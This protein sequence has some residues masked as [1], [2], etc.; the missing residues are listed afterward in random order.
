MITKLI[1]IA[2]IILIIFLIGKFFV[3]N[4]FYRCKLLNDILK[5]NTPKGFV[6]SQGRIYLFISII[7]YFTTLAL[8]FGKS[9]K[10]NL[11]VDMNAI[12]QVIEAEQWAILLMAGYVF[13]N[14][15]LEVIKIMMSSSKNKTANDSTTTTTTTSTSIENGNSSIEPSK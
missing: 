3:C 13:G 12:N 4:L 8:L 14:K 15:G 1:I 5:E 11:G 7:A 6:Y 2:S 9:L 10:P